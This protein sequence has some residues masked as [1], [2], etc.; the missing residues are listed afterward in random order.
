MN[1]ISFY[2]LF[3]WQHN[4]SLL[5]LARESNR[6]PYII[7]DLLLGHPMRRDDAAIILATFNELTGTNYAL[8]QFVI[9]YQEER[10]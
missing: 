7:W 1:G 8:D 6:H 9:V 10:R 3:Q 4:V 5:V 2:R